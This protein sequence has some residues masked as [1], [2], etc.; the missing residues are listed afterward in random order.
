MVN[1]SRPKRPWLIELSSLGVGYFSSKTIFD[2]FH[3]ITGIN[4]SWKIV[5]LCS[6][7]IGLV[8]LFLMYHWLV[9]VFSRQW[10]F[11]YPRHWVCLNRA[12]IASFSTFLDLM[13]FEK[14]YPMIEKL[15]SIE[16]WCEDNCQGAYVVGG[17]SVVAFSRK[18]DA[19]LFVLFTE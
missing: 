17:A 8:L 16:Q 14:Q 10:Q 5:E 2:L 3:F 18:R 15:Y 1:V 11:G 12:Y 19:M 7:L 13:M 9:R 4:V 6:I